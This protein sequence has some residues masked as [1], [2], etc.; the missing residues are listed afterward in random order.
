M[1]FSKIKKINLVI[2]CEHAS[3]QGS[4]VTILRLTKA[5]SY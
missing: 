1:R 4:A 5:E 3:I 2:L